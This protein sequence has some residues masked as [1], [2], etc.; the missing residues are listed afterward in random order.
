MSK[1]IIFIHGMFQNPV[2]W[3]HWLPRFES[4][5]YRCLAP[6]WPFHEGSPADLRQNPPAGLGDLNLE[7]IL[8]SIGGVIASLPE[9]P[10]LIGHSVGGLVVQV[11]VNSGAA[12]GGV[13]ISSVAPNRMLSFDWGFLKNSALINNP[14][15]GNEPFYT[16]LETFHGAFCNTMSIEQ[17]AVAFQETATHD[18]RNVLRT[19]L[20]SAGNV[21]LET[22]HPPLLFVGGSADEIIPADLNEKNA[23][24]YSSDAGVVDL[25]IFEGKAHFICGEPGWEEVADF[26][27]EWVQK[28]FPAGQA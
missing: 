3:Q 25:K 22:V 12:A 10:I 4:L 26:V 5:G 9:K 21:D 23:Q 20:G 11:L 14:L 6:A 2:S 8:E 13:A 15:K 1:T 24:A 27:A 17:T 19:C 7:E 16:D 18:S 28:Q